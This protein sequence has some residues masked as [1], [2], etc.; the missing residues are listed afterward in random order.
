MKYTILHLIKFFEKEEYADQFL[1]G[2]L[3]LN[4]L[5]Y[6]KKLEQAQADGRPDANE[7]VAIWLQKEKTHI[8]FK[9]H[10]ELDIAPE[11]LAGPVQVSFVHYDDL[12]VFCMTARHTGEF[13]F[14]CQ[15]GMICYLEE[16]TEDVKR[17]L[18]VH[19]DCLKMGRFAVI[20]VQAGEFIIRVKNATE[21]ARHVF[22]STLVEYFD[23]DTIH[24]H[25]AMR[26][27]PFRKAQKFAYQSEYRIV[28]DTRTCG[29]EPKRTDIGDIHDIAIKIP[30]REINAFELHPKRT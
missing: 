2:K 29:D 20:V 8:E 3:Y 25:F 23:Q 4:R 5:S 1:Q 26:D 18:E 16:D 6:F 19:E 27:I 15:D 7:A 14:D 30:V 21:K 22:N 24:G 13:E 11:N 9:E 12:H 10:P 28:V 17:Q